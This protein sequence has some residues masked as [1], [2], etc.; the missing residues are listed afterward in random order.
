MVQVYSRPASHIQR[1]GEREN[2]QSQTSGRGIE[3]WFRTKL[4]LVVIFC[5]FKSVV[6]IIP[7]DT[8][9]KYRSAGV[10][11]SNVFKIWKVLSF[12]RVP[13]LENYL[14]RYNL[15]NIK[16]KNFYNVFTFCNLIGRLFLFLRKNFA[17]MHLQSSL[18]LSV[19]LLDC[20]QVTHQLTPKGFKYTWVT[21]VFENFRTYL[22]FPN[23]GQN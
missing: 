22:I 23:T 6:S 17:K 19:P 10:Y 12:L 1:W 3:N 9:P 2:I 21:W 4:V 13:K 8:S 20:T 7:D 11:R 16:C 15:T 18:F 5:W 14:T